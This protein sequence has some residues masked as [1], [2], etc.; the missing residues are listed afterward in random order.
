MPAYQPVTFTA[1]AS[2]GCFGALQLGLHH[3]L[4]EKNGQMD[5]VLSQSI[6]LS[7]PASGADWRESARVFADSHGVHC[8]DRLTAGA[9][10]IRNLGP[11][12]R[13]LP[14]ATH[15][16]P[17]RKGGTEGS[18]PLFSNVPLSL[19]PEL[20]NRPTLATRGGRLLAKEATRGKTRTRLRPILGT[21]LAV[22]LGVALAVA[23][24]ELRSDTGLRRD[25][26]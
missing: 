4:S 18:N 3:C 12:V 1:G 11:T 25:A 21:S 6:P 5:R 2:L 10:Q 17:F 26:D 24:G 23:T 9:N 15:G 13:D 22:M 14:W 8:R 19:L 20:Q 7:R 16:R